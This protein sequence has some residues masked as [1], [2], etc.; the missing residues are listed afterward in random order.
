MHFF[1]CL[2]VTYQS[3]KYQLHADV[4]QQGERWN[5][6]VGQVKNQFVHCIG[7]G[8]HKAVQKHGDNVT[9]VKSHKGVHHHRVRQQPVFLQRAYL[10][11]VR[12]LVYR[13]PAD[14]PV[15]VTEQLQRTLPEVRHSQQVRSN[16]V[17][18]ELEERIQRHHEPQIHN[19][20]Q[21]P[22][23]VVSRYEKS[24]QQGYQPIRLEVNPGKVHH[25]P[26]RPVQFPHFRNVRI[27][28]GKVQVQPESYPP[29]AHAKVFASGSVPQFVEKGRGKHKHQ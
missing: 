28:H 20:Y 3:K 29:V 21:V 24:H 1:E 9:E 13:L 14:K 5:H 12:L 15:Q 10:E 8:L 7:K 18:V 26:L 16:P 4:S 17:T 2:Q 23:D 25:A 11:Q 6:A 27:E 19:K 22:Q